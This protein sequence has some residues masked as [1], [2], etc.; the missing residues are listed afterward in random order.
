MNGFLAGLVQRGASVSTGVAESRGFAAPTAYGDSAYA[1]EAPSDLVEVGSSPPTATPL[2]D[3]ARTEQ[4]AAIPREVLTADPQHSVVQ[5]TQVNAMPAPLPRSSVQVAAESEETPQLLRVM[6]PVR[7]AESVPT[8]QPAD[9]IPQPSRQTEPPAELRPETSAL[10]TATRAAPPAA[11]RVRAPTQPRA[12]PEVTDVSA[13]RRA[14]LD[15]KS[16]EARVPELREV[17]LTAAPVWARE[18][19]RIAAPPPPP[20]APP[21][22]VRIGRVEVRSAAPATAPAAPRNASAAP[23]LGFAAYRRL[24]TYRM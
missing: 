22:H 20:A 5:I 8:A 2:E 6:P 11:D 21:I 4:V 15:V 7:R 19:Q 10:V 23:A 17:T 24:R 12:E 9:R 1:L 3:S 18:L 13:P 16:S 14:S